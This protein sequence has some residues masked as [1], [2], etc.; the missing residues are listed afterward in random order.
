MPA[1]QEPTDEA[2][3]GF[4]MIRI[5]NCLSCNHIGPADT[6]AHAEKVGRMQCPRCNSTGP[7]TTNWMTHVQAEQAVARA[8]APAETPNEEPTMAVEAPTKPKKRS[9]GSEEQ[10]ES[11][12]QLMLLD[13]TDPKHKA[14]ITKLK[15]WRKIKVDRAEALK[16]SKQAED[17]AQADVLAEMHTLDLGTFRWD[18]HEFRIEDREKLVMKTAKDDDGGEGD[19]E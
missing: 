13:I 9:K 4:R 8:T 17:E 5:S 16:E 12:E 2:S 3:K 7:F 6:F 10:P 19:E 11:S 1:V 15:K 18:G 14:L